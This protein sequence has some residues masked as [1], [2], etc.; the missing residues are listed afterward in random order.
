MLKEELRK[1]FTEDEFN[2]F[3][4]FIIENKYF[5]LGK[6]SDYCLVMFIQEFIGSS[7]K[8]QEKRLEEIIQICGTNYPQI[9]GL[10]QENI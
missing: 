9:L 1:L 6:E 7:I 4:L 8:G 5:W 10:V 3:L 2:Q